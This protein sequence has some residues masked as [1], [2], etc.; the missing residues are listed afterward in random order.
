M[1]LSGEAKV[2]NILK[3]ANPAEG[4]DENLYLLETK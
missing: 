2:R 3:E 4:Q 1:N